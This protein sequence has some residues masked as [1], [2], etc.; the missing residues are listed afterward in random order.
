MHKTYDI[1][2][3]GLGAN[4]SSALYQLSK[5]GYKVAGI[6]QFTPPHTKGSSHGQS[7]I[8]RQAYYESPLYVPFLKQAY[9]YWHQLEA[10]TGQQ[11]LLQTGGLMLG[12]SDSVLV[13]GA[14]LSAVTHQVPFEYLAAAEIKERFPALKPEED[15]VA[16]LEKEAGI[17]YPEKCIEAFL[18]LANQHGA[19]LHFNEPVLK[20]IPG[21]TSVDI[22]TANNRYTTQRL[23]VSAGAWLNQLL[24]GLQL[25]LTVA[26]QVLFWL[27]DEAGEPKPAFSPKQ[28]PIYIWEFMP[29]K[30]FYGFANLG[31]GI[32]IAMHHQGRPVE[33]GLL[34]NDVSESEVEDIKNLAHAYL[35]INPVLNYAA[36]CM[37]TNTPDEDFIIDFHPQHPNIIIASPCSGHG[38]KFASFTGKI[39]ADMATGFPV[40]ED[41]SPFSISRFKA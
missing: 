15:T 1:M 16:I 37:Y 32:K 30:M 21:A 19:A 18:H 6:D 27:K 41:I 25:P 9:H 40:A 33:P 24:P 28:L 2:V 34:Q 17:L 39:L 12:S 23:I 38:F 26:R 11:L 35:D 22:I 29:G 10:E 31:E 7:R 36:T 8:I 20:I 4:G 3:L 13:T 14:R 5:T